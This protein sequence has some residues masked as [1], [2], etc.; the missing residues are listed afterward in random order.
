MNHDA[1]HCF[2]YTS[3]CPTECYRA[4]L[5]QDLENRREEF[6]AIPLSWSHFKGTEECKESGA[7]NE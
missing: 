7:N 5:T 4:R 6:I 3:D 1:T 2:D